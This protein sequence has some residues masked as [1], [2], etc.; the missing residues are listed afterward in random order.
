M[1][2]AT[3]AYEV[4]TWYEHSPLLQRQLM[5]IIKRAQRPLEFRAK[6]LFGFTFASFTSVRRA[7]T[8]L[9]N[10]RNI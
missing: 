5:F 10:I 6:P 9:Y 4:R 7:Q 1:E 8:I 2:V 3:A